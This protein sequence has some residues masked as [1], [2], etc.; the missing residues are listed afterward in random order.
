MPLEGSLDVTECHM[1]NVMLI[2]ALADG[3]CESSGQEREA[4]ACGV[5]V[6]SPSFW[7]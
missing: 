7:S 5:H 4:A 2:V 6:A 3:Y 1:R